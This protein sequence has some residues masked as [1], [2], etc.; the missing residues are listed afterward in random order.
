MKAGRREIT[1]VAKGWQNLVATRAFV[2]DTGVLK[3]VELLRRLRKAGRKRNVAVTLVAT[4]GKGSHAMLIFGDSAV[5]IPDIQRELKTGTLHAI[6]KDLGLS[7]K[8]LE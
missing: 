3:G 4:R 7:M 1:A 2:P 5:T 8:D 6:L